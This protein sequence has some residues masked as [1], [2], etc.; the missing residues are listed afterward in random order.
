MVQFKCLFSQ[1]DCK[2]L[3][4]LVTFSSLYIWWQGE[5]HRPMH[6]MPYGWYYHMQINTFYKY[7]IRVQGWKIQRNLTRRKNI[8]RLRYHQ[9]ILYGQ[10]MRSKGLKN[11]EENFPLLKALP[12][13]SQSISWQCV[14]N[15]T[16]HPGKPLILS[17]RNKTD[18]LPQTKITLL[19]NF[20]WETCWT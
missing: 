13:D 17:R 5:L 16:M 2:C 18:E 4:F 11:W 10:L 14:R 3:T 9:G 6:P 19:L 20:R 1:L 7:E 12:S 15:Q 8:S